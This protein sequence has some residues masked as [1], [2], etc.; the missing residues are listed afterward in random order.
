MRFSGSERGMK[1]ALMPSST[2][3]LKPGG[4]ALLFRLGREA[5]PIFLGPKILS[6]LI[7]LDLAF[8][9]FKFIFLG[10]HLAENLYFWIN[11]AYNQGELNDEILNGRFSRPC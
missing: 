1:V 8:C 4:V 7:F 2:N 9:L 5:C 10:S 6:R 11:L 3:P